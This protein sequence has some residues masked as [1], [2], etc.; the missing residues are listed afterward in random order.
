M[1]FNYQGGSM[2][3]LLVILTLFFCATVSAQMTNTS[4]LGLSL[5]GGNTKLFALDVGHATI[6]NIQDAHR[7]GLDTSVQYTWARDFTA[8]RKWKVAGRYDE[9]F[10]DYTA[11][12]GHSWEG[13][14]LAG[15]EYRANTETG[16]RYL[17]SD[18]LWGEMGYVFAYEK[19]YPIEIDDVKAHQ[20]KMKI[21]GK[22]P[23]GDNKY[24]EG[25]A[26]I[27]EDLAN[28]KNLRIDFES[29]MVFE[30]GK[31]FALKLSL[32]G[33]FDNVPAAEQKFDYTYKTAL[34]ANF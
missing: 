17:F 14:T 9:L 25:W 7:I 10:G 30:L 26:M 28:T 1:K 6:Y 15:L 34:V 3:L 8:Q 27:L 31:S 5:S 33:E 23:L 2:K 16:M 18:L 20:V 19:I 13:N 21:H 32:L 22:Q 12:M 29:S 24:F 4:A 11:Y